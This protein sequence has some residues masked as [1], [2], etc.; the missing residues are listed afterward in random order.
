MDA[1]LILG[2]YPEHLD[3]PDES[4]I[5]VSLLRVGFCHNPSVTLVCLVFSRIFHLFPPCLVFCVFV[6]QAWSTS[7]VSVYTMVMQLSA[8]EPYLRPLVLFV[9]VFF[10]FSALLLR[11][12]SDHYRFNHPHKNTFYLNISLPVCVSSWVCQN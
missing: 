8:K 11:L 12:N 4:A 2:I 9:L 3:K 5:Q 10:C 1:T 6:L 7:P